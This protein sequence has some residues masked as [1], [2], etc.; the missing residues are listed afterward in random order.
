M[1]Q[2]FREGIGRWLAIFILALIALTFVFWG[3]DLN[4]YGSNYAARVN[5]EEIPILDYERDFQNQL[6][7]YQQFFLQEITEEIQRELR[8]SSLEGLIR[9]EALSQQVSNEGYIVSNSKLI[10]SIRSMPIFQVDGEFS[11]DIYNSQLLN[12]GL[13]SLEFEALQLEQLLLVELQSSVIGSGFNTLDE[14]RRY[15]QLNNQTREVSYLKFD[16]SDYIDEPMVS[17]IAIEE[18][19]LANQD[20][21]L[22]EESVDIEYLEIKKD[23]LSI[24]VTISDQ[25]LRAFYEDERYRF[26]SEEERSASHILLDRDNNNLSIYEEI[27]FRFESGED[28]E[29]LVEEF[30]IDTGTIGSGGDLGWIA[31]GSLDENFESELFSMQLGELSGL[32]QTNFGEH[33]IKLDEIRSGEVQ[34]FEAVKDQLFL[35]YQEN[36]KE[37]LFYDLAIEL[38]DLSFNAYDSLATVS[39]SMDIPLKTF[40][41]L[42]KSGSSTPFISSP[43]VATIAFSDEI[44][45]QGLNSSPIELNDD[46]VLVLRTTQFNDSN[47][48]ALKDVKLEIQDEIILEEAKALAELDANKFLESLDIENDNYASIASNYRGEWRDSFWVERESEELPSVVVNSLFTLPYSDSQSISKKLVTLDNGDVYVILL[49]GLRY[50]EALTIP[51]DERNQI[52]AQLA[53]QSSLLEFEGYIDLVR[54][55]S[56]VFIP[57]Y[58]TNPVF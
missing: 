36:Q 21:F 17:D 31:K 58:V 24:D 22:T 52:N 39:D 45:S 55:N 19:Y 11:I 20:Q 34:E 15:I 57:E 37:S 8:S 12:S 2:S 14:F 7:D 9:K 26:I 56:E 5:G 30:S 4:F 48:K 51:T 41:S 28:F 40:F 46:H 13:S 33:I 10:G 32:V 49:S 43:E 29:D 50:G 16:I 53:E 23:E 54:A 42:T 18:Y 1:L 6:A 38:A 35:E 3:V 27:V 47:Q 44:L 25:D